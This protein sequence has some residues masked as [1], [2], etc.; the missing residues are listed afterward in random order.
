MRVKSIVVPK[1]FKRFGSLE[2]RDLPVTCELV[3]LVG[4]NGSGKTSLFDALLSW[5]VSSGKKRQ[6]VA[7][8]LYYSSIGNPGKPAVDLHDN[9]P[10]PGKRVHIRTAHR[11][12]P[13]INST[14]VTKMQSIG[15]Q[16]HAD[17]MIEDDK[18]LAADYQRVVG[19]LLPVLSDLDN[20]DANKALDEA[21]SVMKPVAEAM[22]SLFPE[23]RY[24]K[25]GNPT[26]GG[27]F[28]FERDG[29]REFRFE[30]LSG[31]EK[32]AFDLLLDV[33]LVR[34]GIGDAVICIDEPELHINPA[35]HGQLLDQ[36]LRLAGSGSQL[37]VAT[38][39]VGMIRR[40]FEI[41]SSAGD[42]VAFLDFSD[43]VGSAPDVSLVPVPP[44]RQFLKR[45]MTL[46]LDAIVDLTVA[47]RI[48]LC[49]GDPSSLKAPEWDARVYTAIFGERHLGTD[50]ISC[51]GKAE[52]AAAARLARA[53]APGADVFRVRDRDQLT[54]SDRDR[55][56][57]E[58]ASLRILERFSL[59]SYLLDDEILT[60]LAK[61]RVGD[62]TQLIAARDKV[63]ESS[64]SQKAA[65]GTV[66][67][68]AKATLGNSEGLGENKWQFGSGVLAA[69]VTPDTRTYGALE[70]VLLTPR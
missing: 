34:L 17:R 54:E 1:P 5:S 35:L 65:L 9:Y 8:D 60:K 68:A 41:A 36:L 15:E 70:A 23:L 4:P 39:S 29:I 22:Q 12:T 64:G 28:F 37:W 63:R 56:M 46:A 27:S 50:F 53:I 67:E 57:G 45:A 51:G 52:L 26:D 69:L 13:V 48:M 11:N 30:N 42:R 44:S 38:H 40:A 18:S 33:H 14:S 61:E 32:A 25:L 59:E 19:H 62:A 3:L 66:F 31:G 7:D 24:T 49:E 55:L 20:T 43:V 47:D 6:K 2:V 21:R 16:A 58:D 10:T